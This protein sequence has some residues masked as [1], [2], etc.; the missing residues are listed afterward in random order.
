MIELWVV[1]HGETAWNVEGRIQGYAADSPLTP[2][3]EAQ[4]RAV[5]ARLA[6]EGVRGLHASDLGR[7]RQTAAP[8]AAALG[9]EPAFDARLRERNYGVFEGRTY[10]EIERHFPEDWAAFRRREPDHVPPGG[11]SA[12]QF[13]ARV[14]AAF[15]ALAAE[16][17]AGSAGATDPMPRRIAVVT[18][19]GVLGA[20]YR[21]ANALPVDA[22]RSW[23]M[24]NASI[25]VLRIGSGR[26]EL[27]RWG[28]VTHL[29]D[30][31]LDDFE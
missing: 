8:I 27:L 19:G 6:R 16:R 12:A 23:T 24:A 31:S 17:V 3:G 29:D 7:V 2:R 14:A 4:A 15:D 10:E 26:W 22:P 1:R 20:I 9:L 18:H 28:D 30:E 25:N 5:A 13:Q 11:E 21:Q